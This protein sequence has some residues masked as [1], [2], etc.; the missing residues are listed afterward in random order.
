MYAKLQS[1]FDHKIKYKSAAKRVHN[2]LETIEERLKCS[3]L[4]RTDNRSEF[5][6]HRQ[7][8]QL[9][10]EKLLKNETFQMDE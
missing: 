2:F 8:G 3:A 5:W 1:R 9:D 10:L 6:A 7:N 4:N